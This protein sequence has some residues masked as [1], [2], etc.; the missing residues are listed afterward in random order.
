MLV[1]YARVSSENDRQNTDLQMDALKSENID[2][3]H[4]FFDHASGAKTNR[5]GLKK[6]LDFLQSGDSLV[7]WK[8][9]RLGRSLPD[10]LKI[11]KDLQHRGI[12]F[13]SI[14]EAMDTTKPQGQFIFQMFACLAEYE[15][16]LAHERI[17][18]GLISARLRGRKGG[19]PFAIDT[20]KM[21]TIKQL[22]EAGTTKAQIA[23]NFNIPRST[24]NDSLKRLGS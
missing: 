20:E 13:R 3:R 6:A 15:R 16:S 18:A 1:G 17:M 5:P 4:I 21:Q 19:R 14:T 7:V 11:V 12:G 2:S 24:L 22:L 10:L 9:D 23:R 8:L